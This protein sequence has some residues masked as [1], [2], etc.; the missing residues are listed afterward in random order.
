MSPICSGF[1]LDVMFGGNVATGVFAI[2]SSIV[3][4]LDDGDYIAPL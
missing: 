1:S 3:V 4:G 2:V